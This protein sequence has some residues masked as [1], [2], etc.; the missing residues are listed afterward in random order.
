MKFRL[1]VIIIINNIYI[2]TTYATAAVRF[3]YSR[4]TENTILF[5]EYLYWR[6][7]TNI[8]RNDS[9]VMEYIWTKFIFYWKYLMQLFFLESDN[10]WVRQLL[11]N[12]QSLPPL[13]A[14]RHLFVV[15]PKLTPSWVD[16][17]L[18]LAP[19]QLHQIVRISDTSYLKYPTVNS[20]L[21]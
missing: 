1:I 2:Y 21:L 18:Y 14:L 17:K 6:L 3:D 12:L 10:A 5:L 15:A 9:G 13:R 4:G 11:E 7:C 19:S 20:T 16:A 8:C